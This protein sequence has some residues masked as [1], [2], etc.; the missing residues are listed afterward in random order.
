ML[1][2]TQKGPPQNP[3]VLVIYYTYEFASSMLLLIGLCNF[4]CI[5][6]SIILLLV[7]HMNKET[8][9]NFLI[10]HKLFFPFRTLLWWNFLFAFYFFFIYFT[11]FLIEYIFLYFFLSVF[12]DHSTLFHFF[13]LQWLLLYYIKNGM[14]LGMITQIN[15]LVVFSTTLF[16]WI[17][18]L[19]TNYIWFYRTLNCFSIFI[20][21]IIS[22][23]F[24]SFVLWIW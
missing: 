17:E 18:W 2:L 6:Y 13:H 24:L 20:L 8:H 19:S 14:V 21:Q 10:F 7:K 15:L 4:I 23:R 22:I 11:T 3:P 12:Q 5:I 9:E 16:H 1:K